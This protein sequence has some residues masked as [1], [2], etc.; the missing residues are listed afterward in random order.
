MNQWTTET[1]KIIET[2]KVTNKNYDQTMQA[3]GGFDKYVKSLGGIFAETYADPATTQREF[4]KRCEYVQALMSIFRFCYW[5]G[6]T[7]H[8]WL[9]SAAESF[10]DSPQ[11]KTCPT[12]TIRQLCSG[13]GNRTRV[14]NCNYGVDTLSKMLGHSIWSVGY[15][16]MMAKG[17]KKVTDAGKLKPGDLIHFFSG[18]IAK[19]NWKHV[20]IVHSVTDEGVI[21]ADFGS[22]FI[23]TGKPL[24]LFPAEY[25][26]YGA[27]WFGLHWLDLEEDIPMLN[28][29]DIASYQAG[30]DLAKVPGDFVI[31][32][33]TE[34]TGYVNP[35]CN[36]QYAGAKAAGRLLGLYHYA[37]GGD[38]VKEADYFVG[39]IANYVGSAILV[40]DW[41]SGSNA[42]FGKSD[43][44]WCRKWLDRVYEKTGVRPL[45]YMSQSVTNR[46]NWSSVAKDYGLW[47]AQYVVDSRSGY[48]QDYT[49]GVTGA[50][51]HPAIWQYTSGG[52]LPGWSGRLDL[53]VAYMDKSAWAKYAQKAQEEVIPVP[54]TIKQGSTGKLVKMLQ[55]FLGDLTV[56]G[57]FGA[58]TKA[59]VIKWQKAHKLTQDGV[60][61]PKTWRA[62]L[63]S[64]K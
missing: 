21:L 10:Y 54:R 22:R 4:W 50:W 35:Q 56:D 64:L 29:I 30:I 42:S 17:A 27:N 62:I 60:V 7:W 41:E 40:L 2:H 34:G 1:K 31:V 20:A 23:K 16:D 59:A 45:I 57:K 3:A 38:P 43:V 47:L 28:G 33:A 63:E 13:E 8:Y 58:K 52:Y 32:K 48:K 51:S 26:N 24:H 19:K 11:K 53:N 12:G 39:S 44:T 49:H 15:E 36:A 18:S 14:T 55:I 61:G 5:N 46:W 6:T 9:S 25:S 37:N